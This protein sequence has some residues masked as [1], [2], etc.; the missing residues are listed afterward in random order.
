MIGFHKAGQSLRVAFTSKRISGS[1]GRAGVAPTV[2]MRVIGAIFGGCLISYPQ[3]LWAQKNAGRQN[4]SS[5]DTIPIHVRPC[6]FEQEISV[7][8]RIHSQQ[9]HEAKPTYS[10]Q[11][12]KVHVKRGDRVKKGQILVSTNTKSLNQML[13]IYSDY[14]VMYDGFLRVMAKDLK[15]TE[16]RRTQ[17]KGLAAKGII[18]QSELDAAEKAML[19]VISNLQRT[20]RSRDSIQKSVD[21]LHMQI[22]EANFFS[23]IDGV[24][25]DLIANS[26]NMLGSLNVYPG[27]LVARVEKPGVYVAD[28]T[29]ID[30]QVHRLR[31]GMEARIM[32]SD[33]AVYPGTVAFI[34]PLS[35]TSGFVAD[36]G[37]SEYDGTSES[38]KIP[39]PTYTVQIVFSRDGDILPNGLMASATLVTDAI[40]SGRCLPYNT[41]VFSDGKPFINVFSEGLGWRRQAVQIGRRGRFDYEV[42]NKLE[43]SAV[44]QSKLW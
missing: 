26:E 41:L 6:Q 2:L 10:V 43:A 34:S 5:V 22:R 27:T 19:S 32:L 15:V 36:R 8:V 28:A 11:L 9:Q 31:I 38:A 20:N 37:R 21:E 24:V 18:A 35:S 23:H 3:G 40:R 1:A 17:L 4:F 25:T 42:L 12:E 13:N 44:I 7:A 16:A 30:T 33:G 39:L 29:L 14:L